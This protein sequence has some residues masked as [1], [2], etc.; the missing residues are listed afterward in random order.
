VGRAQEQRNLLELAASA[1]EGRIVV[2]EGPRG[3]GKSRLVREVATQAAPL[4]VL[5]C[6]VPASL[7]SKVGPAHPVSLVAAIGWSARSGTA[8]TTERYVVDVM[9]GRARADAAGLTGERRQLRLVSAALESIERRREQGPMVLVFDELHLADDLT[10]T[11]V[12]RVIDMAPV[13]EVSIV[14]CVRDRADVPVSLPDGVMR[15]QLGPL[16]GREVREVATRA[17]LSTDAVDLVAAASRRVPLLVQETLRSITDGWQQ[18]VVDA[19]HVDASSAASL[20][21]GARLAGL[22]PEARAILQAAAI[23]GLDPRASDVAAVL[24][25]DALPLEAVMSLRAAG[26][27]LPAT[28]ERIALRSDLVRQVALE[29]IESDR[30]TELHARAARH[31]EATS[32][33]TSPGDIGEHLLASGQVQAAFD[34]LHR[35]AVLAQGEGAVRRAAHCLRLALGAAEHLDEARGLRRAET[36]RDFGRVL[37][38]SGRLDEAEEIL[39]EAFPRARDEDADHLAADLLRLHGCVLALK[40]SAAEGHEEVRAALSFAEHRGYATVAAEACSDL[41]DAADGE[42]DGAAAKELLE[43]GVKLIEAREDPEALAVRIQ[44]YNRLGRQE[45]KANNFGSAIALFTQALALADR[46]GDRYQGAGLL[47]NLGGAYA[48]RGDMERALHFTEQA[49]RASEA[50]GD[51]IGVSRQSFNLGLLRLA[52]H[53]AP[54]ARKLLQSSHDAA[55]RAGWREGIAMSRAGLAKIERG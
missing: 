18:L 2:L 5:W 26:L 15:E 7:R 51:Q 17:G 11:L 4:G 25:L 36:A 6:V 30:R 8:S 53:Q 47:G 10:W 3:I 43:R 9:L 46:C 28:T 50:I 39:R 29:S 41:A 27:Q 21:F 1:G 20:I 34:M 49:L 55:R 48:R 52:V 12:Q 23:L 37:T 13:L 31:L 38:E 45:L 35:A 14:L 19:Q 24:G 54:L 32:D 22:T 44:L 42:G 16:S 40:G 33:E